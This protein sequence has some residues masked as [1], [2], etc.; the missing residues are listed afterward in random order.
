[1]LKSL[2]IASLI[3]VKKNFIVSIAF[4]ICYRQ[5]ACFDYDVKCSPR[6]IARFNNICTETKVS[7]PSGIE[8]R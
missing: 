4:R 1:M 5:A 6:A 8:L 2:Q 7:T 3:L